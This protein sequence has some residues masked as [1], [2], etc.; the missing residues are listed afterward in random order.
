[1]KGTTLSS[2]ITYNLGNS[3]IAIGRPRLSGATY[4]Y[5]LLSPSSTQHPAKEAARQRQK[6][7]RYQS[8]SKRPKLLSQPKKNR[9]RHSFI[10]TVPPTYSTHHLAMRTQTVLSQERLRCSQTS[11]HSHSLFISLSLAIFLSYLLLSSGIQPNHLGF[12][13]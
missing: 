6:D 2:L 1:M 4:T 10:T 5:V 8:K 12:H 7:G 13:P 9:R 3:S 11:H